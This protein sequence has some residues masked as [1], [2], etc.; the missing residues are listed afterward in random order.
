MS[1]IEHRIK[2]AMFNASCF[3]NSTNIRLDF[4]FWIV[5]ILKENNNNNKKK[6]WKNKEDT[7]ECRRLTQN[8][9]INQTHEKTLCG[10]F[11]SN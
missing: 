3:H 1:E 8:V 7:L 11:S 6:Q 9:I 10:A 4:F 2:D 5:L